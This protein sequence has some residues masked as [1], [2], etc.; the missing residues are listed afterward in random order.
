M[1]ASAVE[2]GQ[3]HFLYSGR[4]RDFVIG[5]GNIGNNKQEKMTTPI[6]PA[7]PSLRGASRS[8][9]EKENINPRSA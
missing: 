7:Q 6:R 8:N 1:T 3:R 5:R 9:P 4:L 2:K